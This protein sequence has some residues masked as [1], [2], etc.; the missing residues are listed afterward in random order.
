[1][2]EILSKDIQSLTETDK[3]NEA[4]IV[5]R[6]LMWGSDGVGNDITSLTPLPVSTGNQG[7]FGT[8]LSFP[9]VSQITATFALPLSQNNVGMSTSGGAT[10]TQGN[11]LLTLAS[12]TATT[13]SVQAYTNN[14]L[15]SSPAREVYAQFSAAFTTPTN[16]NSDQRAGIYNSAN[17]F[18]LGYD[19]LTFGI[20]VRTNS[21]DTFIPQSSFNGD[22]LNGSVSSAFT[23]GGTPEAINFTYL[24]QFRM[25]FAR[26]GVA[27][28]EVFSPDGLWVLFHQIKFPN[29]STQTLIYTSSLPVTFEVIKTASDATNL[30]VLTGSWDAG[31]CEAETGVPLYLQKGNVYKTSNLA[32]QTTSQSAYN[33]SAGRTLRVT[34]LYVS[35]ANSAITT[36]TL[37]I[38]DGSSGNIIIPVTIP[39]S[40]NQSNA[41]NTLSLTF[42]TALL[43]TSSVYVQIAAGTLTYS[44]FFNGFEA[45]F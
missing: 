17:G 12:G 35:V 36:G 22:P 33:V 19:G 2:V 28:F 40:T 16:A 14:S 13:A 25:R 6:K 3:I 7:I 24:N 41:G 8:N 42:P 26:V 45:Y 39:G 27:D 34:T 43:F 23:R 11:G 37:N 44:I 21:V 4:Y 5:K 30:Q 15:N 10:A 1:M 9:R 29:T 38:R 20:T 31:T 18:F 32:S